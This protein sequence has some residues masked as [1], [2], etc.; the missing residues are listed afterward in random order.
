MPSLFECL[1]DD[2]VHRNGIN[3]IVKWAGTEAEVV[4]TSFELQSNPDIDDTL[5]EHPW[6]FG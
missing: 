4:V 1:F 6:K 3:V 2:D 5:T